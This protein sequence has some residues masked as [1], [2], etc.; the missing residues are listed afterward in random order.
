M[1][2][3]SS[4]TNAPA[5]YTEFADRLLLAVDWGHLNIPVKNK[6]RHIEIARRMEEAG[7]SVHGETV[8]KW[9]EGIAFPRTGAIQVLAKVLGVDLSW[10]QMGAG[11]HDPVLVGTP[12]PPSQQS[13][14]RRGAAASQALTG[15]NQE[16]LPKILGIALARLSG[17]RIVDYPGDGPVHFRVAVGGGA[18]LSVHSVI[19]EMQTGGG[20]KVS[21]PVEAEMTY[22]IGI[23]P[24]TPTRFTLV[25]IY[26]DDLDAAGQRVGDRIEVMID[27]ALHSGDVK[28]TEIKG[29]S[30]RLRL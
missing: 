10:L 11:G 17:A 19:G 24:E 15:T 3:L 4:S 6:G 30:G 12:S 16:D 23:L 26:W 8:R 29:F 1:S 5:P 13:S 22:V 18:V 7:Y 20:W 27:K 28:W 25:E 14:R 21:V 9:F 2:A